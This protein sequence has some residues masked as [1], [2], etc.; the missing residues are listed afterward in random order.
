MWRQKIWQVREQYKVCKIDGLEKITTED[1]DWVASNNKINEFC[2][3]QNMGKTAYRYDYKYHLSLSSQ[4]KCIFLSFPNAQITNTSYLTN[5]AISF[6]APFFSSLNM[7][8][9]PLSLTFYSTS[10]FFLYRICFP[11]IPFIIDGF[12]FCHSYMSAQIFCFIKEFLLMISVL[13]WLLLIHYTCVTKAFLL[14]A[15]YLRLHD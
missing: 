15:L 8:R 1:C 3:V 6:C 10:G 5:A 9:H 4:T 7:E 14:S 12:F 13:L 2:I 11:F